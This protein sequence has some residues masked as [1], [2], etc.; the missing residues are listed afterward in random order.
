MRIAL[1]QGVSTISRL[2]RWQSRSK[3]SHAA[4][5]CDDGSVIEAWM[6]EVRLVSNLSS[7]HTPG[8]LVD[9]FEFK[10]QL[11]AAE[12]EKL[13]N[14]A[15]DDLAIPYDYVGIWRFVTRQPEC[16]R[17]K[18]KL[19][20][21]EQVFSRCGM[22]GRHLLERTEAW[23]VPPDWIARSPLLRPEMSIRTT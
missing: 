7:Q 14:L 6:P 22:I 16:E 1:Y 8:T 18:K 15:I 19:F 21:S 23:R 2:I 9:I 5:L 4:F 11:T 3:Y 12:D 20:C 13:W 17:S 10:A